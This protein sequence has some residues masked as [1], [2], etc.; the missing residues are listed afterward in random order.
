MYKPIERA[1]PAISGNLTAAE[2]RPK[3]QAITRPAEKSHASTLAI[4]AQAQATPAQKPRFGV[5]QIPSNSRAMA[6][7]STIP[8]SSLK[9]LAGAKAANA[10]AATATDIPQYRWQRRKMS[11]TTSDP[12]AR[13]S[14]RDRTMSIDP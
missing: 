8:A 7:G 4:A 14:S 12:Q 13:L 1:Q 10:L 5:N 2:R 11:T 6:T 9:T 3:I